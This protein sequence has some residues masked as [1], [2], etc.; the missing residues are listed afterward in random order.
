M[1]PRVASQWA[2]KM[3]S[4]ILATSVGWKEGMPPMRSQRVAPLTFMGSSSGGIAGPDDQH[5]QD[6]RD[7]QAQ[8]GERAPVAVVKA[9][10]E[11]AAPGRRAGPSRSARRR[12]RRR[13]LQRGRRG[14]CWSRPSGCRWRRGPEPPP[15]AGSRVRAAR[16]GALHHASRGPVVAGRLTGGVAGGAYAPPRNRGVDALARETLGRRALDRARGL[17]RGL[18]TRAGL[19]ALARPEGAGCDLVVALRRCPR[20]SAVPPSSKRL[21][22]GCDGS[23]GGLEGGTASLVVGEHVER[24][25]SRAEQH[26]GRRLLTGDGGGGFDGGRHGGGTLDP[27]QAGR[28]EGLPPAPRRS[29]R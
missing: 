12:R 15:A 9:H 13:S 19:A 28:R 16:A 18:R 5:Q 21:P 26:G 20:G 10:H 2:R 22:V 8:D 25:R 17:P 6:Q 27:L 29:H 4:A 3:T 7:G 1:L 23:H 11:D 14:R 24:G